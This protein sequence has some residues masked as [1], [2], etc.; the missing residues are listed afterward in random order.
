MRIYTSIE[1]A[2]VSVI[3]ALML[4]SAPHWATDGL[5]LWRSKG[6]NAVEFLLLA[7]LQVLI[8]SILIYVG[9]LGREPRWAQ[10]FSVPRKRM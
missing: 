3:A 7:A 1:R 8:A 6:P 4:W 2:F 10:R 5:S 9:V